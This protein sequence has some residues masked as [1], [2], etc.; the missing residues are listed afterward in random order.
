MLLPV[1]HLFSKILD[2]RSESAGYRFTEAELI[3][4]PYIIVIGQSFIKEKKV[5]VWVRQSGEKV[6]D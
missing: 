2:D 1:L 3:G 6:F 4:Y 5:E